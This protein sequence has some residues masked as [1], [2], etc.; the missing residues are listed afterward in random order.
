MT[1]EGKLSRTSVVLGEDSELTMVMIFKGKTSFA[2]ND[3]G[4]KAAKTAEVL[5]QLKYF[6]WMKVPTLWTASAED[7][8]IRAA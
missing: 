7:I 1:D 5:R 8:W 4:I 2:A 3:M 6:S